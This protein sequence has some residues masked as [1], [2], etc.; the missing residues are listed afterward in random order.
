[1]IT[2]A[3]DREEGMGNKDGK[4][5]KRG[6][7]V[8]HVATVSNYSLIPLNT[9]SQQRTHSLELPDLRCYRIGIEVLPWRG[10][11]EPFIL[12]HI[13]ISC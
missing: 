9:L 6:C 13:C 2:T 5:T 1:M 7:I 12:H 3:T 10:A 8:N 11:P 4:V